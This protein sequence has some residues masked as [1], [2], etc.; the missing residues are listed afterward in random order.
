LQSYVKFVAP[1]G[2]EGRNTFEE[3]TSSGLRTGSAASIAGKHEVLVERGLEDSG[4]GPRTTVLV[5]LDVVCDTDPRLRFLVRGKAIVEIASQPEVE[6][7]VP[8]CDGVL[9]IE[10]QELMSVWPLKGTAFLH[11]SGHT[12]PG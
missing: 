5:F 3:Q 6:R 4:V 12:G 10:R 11:G 1:P 2:A 7:P 8:F 9:S